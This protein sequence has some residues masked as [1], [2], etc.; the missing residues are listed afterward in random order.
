MAISRPEDHPEGCSADQE[1]N[2]NRQQEWQREDVTGCSGDDSNAAMQPRLLPISAKA[3]A[4]I[5]QTLASRSLK[6]GA[7]KR[8]GPS[9]SYR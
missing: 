7:L 2:C 3:K 8:G 9:G 6:C 5:F 4:V 1:H